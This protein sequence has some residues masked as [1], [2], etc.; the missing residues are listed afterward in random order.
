MQTLGDATDFG[1]L[2]TGTKGKAG[3]TNSVRGIFAGGS[4]PSET[5]VMEYVTISTKGNTIDFGDSV[6]TGFSAG[7]S[8][9]HGG[10]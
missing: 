10:L 9:A 4:N 2:T 8:N 3:M 1:D 6:D 5:D 7:T